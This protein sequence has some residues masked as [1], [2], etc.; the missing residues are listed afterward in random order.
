MTENTNHSEHDSKGSQTSKDHVYEGDLLKRRVKH[1]GKGKM[2]YAG[3]AVYEGDWKDGKR[4]G[5][6]EMR[7]PNGAVYKGIFN[8]GEVREGIYFNTTNG[9]VFKGSMRSV[10]GRLTMITGVLSFH[11][12]RSWGFIRRSRKSVFYENGVRSTYRLQDS[13]LKQPWRT[14]SESDHDSVHTE[15]DTSLETESGPPLTTKSLISGP[16]P[17]DASL[18]ISKSLMQGKVISLTWEPL[19]NKEPPD[20][21]SNKLWIILFCFAIC[22]SVVYK[23][24]STV[25]SNITMP[26]PPMP[27]ECNLPF[28][29]VY[30]MAQPI[31]ALLDPICTNKS[32][33]HS[34]MQYV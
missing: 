15:D 26:V 18:I 14:N 19:H 16:M 28:D 34:M 29:F 8:K 21:T 22:L 3:G 23:V 2:Q 5:E 9:D 20:P 30:M 12:K 1:D 7:W 25:S 32:I 17:P 13:E 10:G 27:F 11:P 4:H 31:D 33:T 6:G 24:V